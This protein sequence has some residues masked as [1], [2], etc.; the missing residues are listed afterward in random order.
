MK[1]RVEITKSAAKDYRSVSSPRRERIAEKI[2]KL[3]ESGLET[4]NIKA[5]TG[6][7]KG[8]YRLRSG[9]YRIVFDIEKDVITILAIHDRE[10]AY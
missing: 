3:K 2:D 7:L 8:L 1:Y 4:S 5:L 9:D 6:K 10:E